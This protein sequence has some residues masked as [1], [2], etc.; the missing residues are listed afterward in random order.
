MTTTVVGLA[1][2]L[3]LPSAS[4]PLARSASQ[5]CDARVDGAAFP[6]LVPTHLVWDELWQRAV[7]ADGAPAQR[8][9]LAAELGIQ[10]SGVE[11]IALTALGRRAFA[12]AQRAQ[13][14]ATAALADVDASLNARDR[15][16]SGLDEKGAEQIHKWLL[17][18]SAK[19]YRLGV[20]G[21][22]VPTQEG[23]LLCKASVNGSVHPQL[24]PEWDSWR[25]YFIFMRDGS[26]MFRN[27]G[28]QYTSGYL[29]ALQRRR[30]VNSD[31]QAERLLSLMSQ[32][33]ERIEHYQLF[34]T[35]MSPDERNTQVIRTT[36]LM[37][38]R[39]RDEFPAAT[40]V[41]VQEEVNQIRRG[42]TFDFPPFGEGIGRQ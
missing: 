40:W 11:R 1:L 9:K 5:A 26:A 37:R 7:E 18:R 36:M 39:V 14:G 3:S 41:A 19:P 6:F 42:T 24:I 12:A 20:A 27:S 10:S 8:Q 35:S 32:A 23:K 17:A 22:L 4:P 33:A 30:L 16:L 2:L 34:A 29:Q 25:N 15:L 21:Q 31:I 13:G 38:S 28:G